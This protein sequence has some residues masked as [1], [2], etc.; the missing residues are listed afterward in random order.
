MSASNFEER[1]KRVLTPELDNILQLFQDTQQSYPTDLKRNI[2][3]LAK[4]AKDIKTE[5][6]ILDREVRRKLPDKPEEDDKDKKPSVKSLV[7]SI[8]KLMDGSGDTLE[9]LAET[10]RG[11]KGAAPYIVPTLIGSYFINKLINN[12]FDSINRKISMG[13]DAVNQFL[14]EIREDI[15]K[16]IRY[17]DELSTMVATCCSNLSA[18]FS[19]LDDKFDTIADR[20]GLTSTTED[21]QQGTADV[22]SF[23]EQTGDAIIDAINGLRPLTDPLPKI[24]FENFMWRIP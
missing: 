16:L 1:V 22:N 4:I 15:E 3:G 5:I 8:Q 18:K 23:T 19:V 21:V 20:V 11:V 6:V 24:P 7:Q 13:E 14:P 17:N 12:A 10:L 2:E 9:A